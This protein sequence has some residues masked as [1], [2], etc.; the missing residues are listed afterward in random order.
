M[1]PWTGRARSV[2]RGPTAART[3]GGGPG[4]GGALT[5]AR[6]PAAQFAKAHRRGRNRERTLVPIKTASFRSSNH[7]C[8]NQTRNG[9]Q[10]ASDP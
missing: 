4:R 2:H 5:G 8:S 7:S 1:P 6:P 3:E 9:T 10:V